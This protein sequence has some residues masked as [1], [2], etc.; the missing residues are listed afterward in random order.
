[1]LKCEHGLG[2]GDG[3]GGCDSDSD[4]PPWREHGHGL[5]LF[6]TFRTSA[7]TVHVYKKSKKYNVKGMEVLLLLRRLDSWPLGSWELPSY[8]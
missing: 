5:F 7:C 4:T 8:S 3:G 1:M 6:Y 2:L